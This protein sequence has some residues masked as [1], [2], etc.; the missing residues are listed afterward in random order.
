MRWYANPDTALMPSTKIKADTRAWR[1]D[2]D[3]ILGFWDE[4]LIGD[5]DACIPTTDMLEAFNSWLR[6]NGHNEWSKELFGPRFAQHEQTIQHGVTRAKPRKL[7][8]LSRPES[9]FSTLPARPEVYQGVRFQTASDKEE[10]ESGQTGQTSSETFSYTRNSESFPKGMTSLTTGQQVCTY[11]QVGRPCGRLD[12][13]RYEIGW[14]CEEHK[15]PLW[16]KPL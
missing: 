15:P 4:Q 12:T 10:R 2:A 3:R 7:V 13:M 11:F 16:V 14:L 5:R 1:A 6:G 8:G 9:A